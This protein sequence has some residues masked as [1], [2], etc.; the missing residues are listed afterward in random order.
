M[1]D[2]LANLMLR[3]LRAHSWLSLDTYR[4]YVEEI[5]KINS[6]FLKQSSYEEKSMPPERLKTAV[7]M[8]GWT[9]VESDY[10][11]LKMIENVLGEIKNF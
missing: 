3:S 1:K 5:Q 6:M 10:K 9:Y 7:I 8:T 2:F 4:N 11:E